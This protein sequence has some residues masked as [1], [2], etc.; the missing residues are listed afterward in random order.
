[1]ATGRTAGRD[2]LRRG[3][4]AALVAG[5]LTVAALA[6]GAG[7]AAAAA[8]KGTSPAVAVTSPR[9]RVAPAARTGAP[10]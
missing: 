5:A 7:R 6:G 10:T 8:P 2:G 9:S 1:M 4:P 3:V